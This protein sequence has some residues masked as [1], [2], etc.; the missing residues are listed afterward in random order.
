MARIAL[1]HGIAPRDL[2]AW[3]AVD[4]NQLVV[5]QILSLTPPSGFVA[6]N[7]T[8]NPSTSAPISLPPSFIWPINGRVLTGYTEASR[9]IDIEGGRDEPVQASANGVVVYSGNSLKGY[10]NL[11]IIKHDNTYLTAYAN[12]SKLLVKEGDKVSKGQ[13]ISEI[14]SGEPNTQNLHF[15]IRVNGK[16]VDP[17]PY[18]NGTVTA[19]KASTAPKVATSMEDYKNKCK[20]LG[21]KSGTED[22]GKCVLQLSK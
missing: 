10:G 19:I 14:G 12:N 11:I 20:E 21:F 5:G 4:P 13:K 9:G 6:Q 16:P 3:N 15:E 2:V 1:D 17:L 8:A 22:F 7:S 18:L